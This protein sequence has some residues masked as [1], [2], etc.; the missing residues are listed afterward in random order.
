[1][2]NR[3]QAAD[4]MLANPALQGQGQAMIVIVAIVAQGAARQTQA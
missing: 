2:E 3:Y 1:M 4:A